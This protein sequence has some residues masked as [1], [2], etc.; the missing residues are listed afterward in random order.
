MPTPQFPGVPDYD[1]AKS[2]EQNLKQLYDAYIGVNRYL[3][4][5]LSALDT[6]NVS[7]LD[8]KV[9]VANTVTADKMNVNELSAISADLG[10]IEAGEVYGAYIATSHNF[11]K[12]EFT[13]L[14]NFIKAAQDPNRY[15]L[16]TPFNSS[17]PAIQ[18]FDGIIGKSL[19]IY[20]SPLANGTVISTVGELQI[21]TGSSDLKLT[22]NNVLING[23]NFNSKADKSSI[24]KVVYVSA[25]PGGP[26]DTPMI[27][28]N[29][30]VTG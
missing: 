24:S 30:I 1:S 22:G 14:D 4:Y 11:P 17:T 3:T 6:L 19:L 2:T 29:G 21:G 27:V 9:I 16:V 5:L 20:I 7:R 26:A 13:S 10:T 28:T 25:T 23:V 18:L 8:A 15:V 12:V